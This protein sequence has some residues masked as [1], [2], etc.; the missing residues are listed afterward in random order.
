L[1]FLFPDI[2]V[3]DWY[4]ADQRMTRLAPT[5]SGGMCSRCI[6]IWN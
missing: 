4:M 3:L 5:K 6:W 2:L 1:Q